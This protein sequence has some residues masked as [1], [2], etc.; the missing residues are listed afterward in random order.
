MG[1]FYTMFI[2]LMIPVVV[3]VGIAI[4]SSVKKRTTA[5]DTDL[6][7]NPNDSPLKG[8]NGVST[9]VGWIIVIALVVLVVFIGFGLSSNTATPAESTKGTISKAEYIKS[10]KSYNYKDLMRDPDAYTGK[11]IYI[12]GRVVQVLQSDPS[13]NY[14]ELRVAT[15]GY[16]DIF[17]VTYTLKSSEKRI[18][19]DDNIILYGDFGGLISY[20]SIFGQSITIPKISAKFMEMESDNHEPEQTTYPAATTPTVSIGKQNAL[21][22]AQHYLSITAFSYKG[23]TKQLEFEGFTEEEVLYGVENCGANWYEQAAK[24]AKHYLDNFS[25]S[26]SALIKQLEFEGFTH[27]QAVYGAEANGY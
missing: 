1:D 16:E 9:A 5:L 12:K 17:Y 14:Y 8:K 22:S 27:E 21:K 19:E 25:L 3:I 6:G 13:S 18:L 11:R 7:Y 10:C 20:K 2:F 23:L 4:Y 24:S 26:R 15:S